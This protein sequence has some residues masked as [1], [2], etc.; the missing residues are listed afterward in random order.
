VNQLRSAH[1]PYNNYYKAFSSQVSWGRLE[2]KPIGTEIQRQNT[3]EKEG[4]EKRK[5]DKKTQTEKGGKQ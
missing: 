3:G 4:E 1:N 5:G 2:M